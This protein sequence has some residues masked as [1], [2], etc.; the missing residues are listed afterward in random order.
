METHSHKNR[1]K[2]LFILELVFFYRYHLKE[3]N[4]EL[5]YLLARKNI[6]KV[7]PRILQLASQFMATLLKYCLGRNKHK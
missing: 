6:N 1:P 3:S 2:T 5:T 4:E 7:S